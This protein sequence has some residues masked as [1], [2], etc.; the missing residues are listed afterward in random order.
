MG[1][2]QS[3]LTT[4]GQLTRLKT[5]GGLSDVDGNVADLSYTYIV[6]RPGIPAWV[7]QAEIDD[8]ASLGNVAS[9]RAPAERAGA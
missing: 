5:T 9:P 2:W 3:T 8:G 7:Q 4:A 6:K 1:P